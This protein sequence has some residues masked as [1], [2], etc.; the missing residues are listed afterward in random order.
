VKLCKCNK[1]SNVDSRIQPLGGL[2]EQKLS[3]ELIHK[4]DFVMAALLNPILLRVTYLKFSHLEVEKLFYQF[5]CV[6]IHEAEFGKSD[7]LKTLSPNFYCTLH[8]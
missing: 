3:H 6:L 8:S 4:H 2:T 1:V 5:G 7:L